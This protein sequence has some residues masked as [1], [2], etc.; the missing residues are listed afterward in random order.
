[1]DPELIGT[2]PPPQISFSKTFDT[3][4]P[5]GPC[6]TSAAVCHLLSNLPK[7]M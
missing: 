3:F 4:C 2:T 5:M 7:E 6:I 1:M